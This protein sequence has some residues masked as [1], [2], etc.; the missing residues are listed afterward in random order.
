VEC[1]NHTLDEGIT[2][3]LS[4]SGLSCAWW[5]DATLHFLYRKIQL[6]SSVT[7]PDILYN[8]FYGKK[9]SI[10]C[11]WP[12]GCLVYVHLQKDQHRAFQLHALHCILVGYPTNY[13]GW[14]F[15]DPAAHKEVISNSTIFCESVFPH[16]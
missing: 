8:L 5:E 3:L 11:L 1:L 15:W 16:Q 4:Q 10:K 14:H 6:P 12:F 13:K 7:A 2:T 9:G